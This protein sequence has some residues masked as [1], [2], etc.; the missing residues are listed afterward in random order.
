M[1]SHASPQSSPAPSHPPH[2]LPQPLQRRHPILRRQPERHLF[3]PQRH[4]LP[5]PLPTLINTPHNRRMPH[6][7]IRGQ[8]TLSGRRRPSKG[9][10]S[11]DRC[12]FVPGAVTVSLHAS[13]PEPDEADRSLPAAP[14]LSP[15]PDRRP[16]R[17]SVERAPQLH[18]G[19]DP[20]PPPH[21]A[22]DE[23]WMP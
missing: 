11:P 23:S 13:S 14:A 19:P 21:R 4:N 7:G 2:H 22:A 6:E 20:P 3:R 15:L 12:N 18:P 9:L 8:A 16:R 17:W 5:H 10:R 1:P